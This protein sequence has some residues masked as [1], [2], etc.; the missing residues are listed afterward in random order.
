M[1]T[2]TESERLK[3][4]LLLAERD[5]AKGF[6]WYGIAMEYRS[7]GRVDDA[8]ATFKKLIG[9]DPKYVPA[10]HQMGLTLRDAGRLDEAKAAF[11][12]GI[13]M[14]EKVGNGHAAGEMQEAL[15]GID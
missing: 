2:A 1:S 9:L 5:P 10:Y 12:E 13:G 7:L 6:T 14:A 8:I 3:N 11:R 15:E 4:L